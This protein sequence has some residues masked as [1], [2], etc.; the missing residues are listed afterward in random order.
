MADDIIKNVHPNIR[1]RD[2]GDGSQAV[3]VKD[4]NSDAMLAAVLIKTVEILRG[5]L[6]NITATIANGQTTSSEIDLKGASMGTIYLPAAFT[7]TSLTF[8]AAPTAGGTHQTVYDDSNSAITVTVTQGRN[9]P[10]PAE[11]MNARFIK[12]V[13][14]GAEGAARSIVISL[15]G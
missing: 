1:T 8:T 14:S 3:A 7:G 11:V 6:T 15:K 10:I 13:S 4:V 5:I 2:L 12:L 9:Y